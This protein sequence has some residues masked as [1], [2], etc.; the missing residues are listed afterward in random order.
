MR[1]V[2]PA[3]ATARLFIDAAAGEST[4]VLVCVWFGADVFARNDQGRDALQIALAHGHDETADV[5]R[6]L[7]GEPVLVHGLNAVVH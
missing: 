4:G 5:L 2:T 6:Q 7:R 3:D 1:P